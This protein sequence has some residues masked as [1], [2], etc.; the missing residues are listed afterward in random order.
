MTERAR[1]YLRKIL[2]LRL[3]VRSLRLPPSNPTNSTLEDALMKT[4]VCLLLLCSVFLIDATRASAQERRMGNFEI[5]DLMS[6]FNQA[7]TLSSNLKALVAQSMPAQYKSNPSLKKAWN[8]QTKFI[9][10]LRAS[11]DLVI[12]G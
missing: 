12:A 3:H 2:L 5:Q 6:S 8:E 1:S 9:E 11:L 7:E 4:S 10:R